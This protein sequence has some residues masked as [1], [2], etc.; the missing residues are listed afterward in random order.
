MLGSLKRRRSKRI[1]QFSLSKRSKLPFRVV[2]IREALLY[3]I[4]EISEAACH[5]YENNKLCSAFTLTRSALETAALL[6]LL[7][8]KVGEIIKQDNVGNIDEFL[9]KALFGSRNKGAR[10]TALNV[11]T[12]IDHFNKKCKGTRDYYDNLSNYAHPNFDGTFSMFA[13]HDQ[14]NKYTNFSIFPNKSRRSE[15]LPLLCIAL[16]SFQYYYESIS[17]LIPRF[18]QI[19]EK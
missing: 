17:R 12:A 11:L 15:G 3:R 13:S 14:Q 5:L 10:K 16:K 4:A 19:C 1:H 18:V 7:D 2:T 8:K 9:M 6:F